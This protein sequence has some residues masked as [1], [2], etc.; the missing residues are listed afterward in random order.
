M[1]TLTMADFDGRFLYPVN[2]RRDYN[3]TLSST[4]NGKTHLYGIGWLLYFRFKLYF[5]VE[6]ELNLIIKKLLSL[7]LFSINVKMK[8]YLCL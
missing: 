6:I 8:S 4:G 7:T 2:P 5:R 1:K 3:F